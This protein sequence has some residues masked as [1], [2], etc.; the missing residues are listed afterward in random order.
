KWVL[1]AV[2]S[3]DKP[4][5]VIGV[6]GDGGE[7]PV[8]SGDGAVTRLE[9][10]YW[11]ESRSVLKVGGSSIPAESVIP[12]WIYIEDLDIRSAYVDYS[13][14][15]D[16]GNTS[17]YSD[18]AAAVH[19]EVG[20]N[21]TVRGCVLTDSGNG[22]FSGSDSID[23][24]IIGNH[25]YGNGVVGNVYEHNSYTE[26][27]G[28]LFE[29][30]RYGALRDGAEGNNLKDRSSGTV[31]RYNWIEGGN[32][33]LD[34]VDSGHQD[35]IDR[36]DYRETWVVGNVLIEPD[37]AGNSQIV[38]YG[39]DSGDT[40]RYRAGTLYFHHN[41][42]VSHRTGNTTLVRLSTGDER[43]E[44]RNNLLYAVG[45]LGIVDEDGDAVL[46]G[47][48]LQDGWVEAV[49]GATGTVSDLGNLTGTDP[50][51]VDPAGQDFSL[52]SG[53]GCVDAGVSLSEPVTGQYVPHQGL[54]VRSDDGSP[55]CGALER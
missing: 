2:A 3:E 14:T 50:G 42:V 52:G 16:A 9:L 51:F 30:N 37:G 31:I 26:S 54:T 47:N 18:N 27:E 6:P 40:S 17:I 55:D 5:V 15:D 44:A 21:I 20:R 19:V 41:T 48:W 49:T 1:N 23:L 38:H 32:R 45:T 22:L 25:I 4:L 46:E 39:G 7:L 34:L 43:I 10:D 24:H 11:N 28:I 33:Q 53:A 8:I 13:F 29:A 12:S 36:D 35:L